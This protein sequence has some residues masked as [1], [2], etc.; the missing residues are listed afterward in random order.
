MSR[1]FIVL[2]SDN[3]AIPGD[4]CS[5]FYR[6]AQRMMTTMRHSWA[7]RIGTLAL[8]NPRR[9]QFTERLKRMK[10]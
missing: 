8:Y 7:I 6:L 4:G 5:W 9:E 3:G 2:V 1:L 10:L